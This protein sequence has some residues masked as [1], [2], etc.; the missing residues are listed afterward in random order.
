MNFS[1]RLTAVGLGPGDPEL[2]TVKGWRAIES[3]DLVFVP[4]SQEGDQSMALRIA[5]PWLNPERQ[6]LVGLSMPMTRDT[7]RLQLAWQT[8]ADQIAAAFAD[9][10]DLSNRS[11]LSPKGVYLLL[12]DPLLYGTFT[13]I[14]GELTARYPH[15][16]VEIIPGITSFAAAAARAGFP[17]CTTSERVAILPASYETDAAQLQRLLTGYETVILFKVGPVLPKIL[18]AL[19]EMGLLESA[20]YAEH[21]G[22]PE[23][24]IVQ[25]PE[26][27]TLL[28]QRRPY[29]SLLIVKRVSSQ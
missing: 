4:R 8:A 19:D 17:L 5:Q 23:E 27:R 18:A 7:A 1:P 29:L 13:Y 15:I 16:G 12:G 9:R 21:V 25:G 10:T 6:Q 11:N 3:A 22:M 14:W 2:I 28:N 24:R 20:L 26:V